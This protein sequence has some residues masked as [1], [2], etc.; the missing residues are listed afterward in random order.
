M[1]VSG[2]SLEV[3]GRRVVGLS[4]ATAGQNEGRKAARNSVGPN[5]AFGSQGKEKR[6]NRKNVSPGLNCFPIH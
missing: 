1:R 2:R 3:T 6:R 4:V 5:V